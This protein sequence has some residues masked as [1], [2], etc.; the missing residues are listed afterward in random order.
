MCSFVIMSGLILL[1]A[2]LRHFL[3][4][5]LVKVHVC[6]WYVR[7]GLKMELMSSALVSM[8]MLECFRSG[9]S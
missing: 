3:S 5:L 6:H 8:G 2:V 1:M 9:V 7:V 4:R